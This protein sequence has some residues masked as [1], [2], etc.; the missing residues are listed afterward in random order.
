MAGCGRDVGNVRADGSAK[1][2]RGLAATRPMVKPLLMASIVV[3]IVLS[4]F[5]THLAYHGMFDDPANYAIRAAG[6]ASL[7]ISAWLFQESM[8][9]LEKVDQPTYVPMWLLQ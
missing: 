1:N 8:Q 9:L 2:G 6:L 3:L 5:G 7:I 4:M